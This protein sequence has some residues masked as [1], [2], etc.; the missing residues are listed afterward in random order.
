MAP[1]PAPAVMLVSVSSFPHQPYL[2]VRDA[3]LSSRT[4]AL[5]S[6]LEALETM[7]HSMQ[8]SH[9][10][11]NSLRVET[12]QLITVSAQITKTLTVSE[13]KQD[14]PLNLSISLSGGK[15]IN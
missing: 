5:C 10:Y 11:V 15:E 9:S 12:A 2:N 3:L 8:Q 4:R 7:P 6:L 14:Y 13:I 1:V